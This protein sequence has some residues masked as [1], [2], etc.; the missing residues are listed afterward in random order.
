MLPSQ[1][2]LY[3]RFRG[4]HSGVEIGVRSFE[5][6]KPWFVKRM[7]EFNSCC[8]RYHVQMVELKDALNFMRR[9][10]VH[11]NCS[12]HCDVCQPDSGT[13]ACKASELTFHSVTKLC[14]LV[15]CP[16]P[17]E[18]EFHALSCIHGDCT[19]CGATKLKIYPN[20][21]SDS[22]SAL[23]SW[24]R[25]EMVFVGRGED[26]ND[27][28]AL[29][30]EHKMTPPCELVADLRSHLEEFLV[31]NFEAKWQDQQF[32]VCMG[33]LSPD[34]IVSVIDFAENYAFK[35]QNEV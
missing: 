7:K 10:T 18:E 32:K 16:K 5:A 34:A 35:W 1:I 29:R 12:C 33:N 2:S 30:L 14:E 24:K 20:E 28:H 8:C 15:L 26:G 25:F 6:L 4:E 17:E 23:V 11:K 13:G 22:T 27:R 31:H 9:G 3:M 21:L 19:M